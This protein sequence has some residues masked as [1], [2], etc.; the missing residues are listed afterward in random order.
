MKDHT[1][2]NGSK[3]P[4]GARAALPVGPIHFDEKYYK[5]ATEFDGFRFFNLRQQNGDLPDYHAANSSPE[6]LTFGAGRH[7]WYIYPSFCFGFGL[8]L[9]RFCSPGRFFA[10]SE[11]KALLGFTLLTYDVKTKDGK[12][13]KDQIFQDMIIPDMTAEILIRKRV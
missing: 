10:V 3:V 6:H 5:N 4:K 13:P 8:S 9:T 11:L 1:F 12:R 2:S 7:I